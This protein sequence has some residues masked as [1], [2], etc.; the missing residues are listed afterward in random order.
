MSRE[1]SLRMLM[2]ATLILVGSTAVAQVQPFRVNGSGDTFGE[3]LSVVGEP[4]IHNA[5]GFGISL[6][7]YTGDEGIFQS[8]SFDP[9][10]GSGTFRGS[11]VFVASNGDRLVCTYGD[12]DNGAAA[13]G[14]YFAVPA[15]NGL[16]QIVFCAEFNPLVTECTGRY[17]NLVGG[18]V[19]ML[20]MT[21]P[22]LLVI[23]ENG[24]TPPFEYSWE[25]SGYLEYARR[26]R[27]RN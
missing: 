1:F 23:D 18:S 16:A 25:G 12:V 11:F 2:G 4:G 14:D 20:A 5:A 24:K 7:Q 26:S 8:L 6:G 13:P 17:R 21:A 19:Q 10:T 22:F 15:E 3:G 9:A 27:R